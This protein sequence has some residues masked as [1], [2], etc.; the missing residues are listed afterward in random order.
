MRLIWIMVALFFLVSLCRG[1]IEDALNEI[2]D[3]KLALT[4]YNGNQSL[5]LVYDIDAFTVAN[6][7]YRLVTQ[8]FVNSCFKN[9]V[10][11]IW[12]E[13][14]FRYGNFRYGF[15]LVHKFPDSWDVIQG[16]QF[17]QLRVDYFLNK[18]MK[19]TCLLQRFCKTSALKFYYTSRIPFLPAQIDVGAFSLLDIYG[20][21][22][23]VFVRLRYDFFKIGGFKV[24]GFFSKYQRNISKKFNQTLEDIKK[25]ARQN[26]GQQPEHFFIQHLLK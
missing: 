8:S 10:S 20:A 12:S 15:K 26:K 18:R 3:I 1:Q 25:G 24:N 22:P 5:R 17:Q 16:K 14:I 7:N 21:R 4:S 13:L 9:S 23:A 2:E 19:F 11:F 6:C